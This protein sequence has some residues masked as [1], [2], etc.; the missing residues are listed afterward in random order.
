MCS[1]N[2]L[3]RN[4]G[5]ILRR[6]DQPQRVLVLGAGFT[7]LAAGVELTRLNRPF[8][9]VEREQAVG[10]LSKTY[11]MEGTSFELGPHIY[12]NKDPEVSRYWKFFLGDS[13]KPHSRSNRIYF[14]GA[15]IK[16]PLSPLD[17][18]SK[19]GLL[20]VTYMIWTFLLAKL[21]KRD[22][23]SAED[24]V[25]SNFGQGLYRYFFK[26]YNEKIWGLSCSEISPNWAG[27][28]IKSNLLTMVISSFRRRDKLGSKMFDFPDGGS[29]SLLNAQL[30][31]IKRSGI[32]EVKLACHPSEIRRLGEGFNVMFSDGTEAYFDY[33]IATCHLDELVALLR[34]FEFDSLKLL[35]RSKEL[36]YRNL[37]VVNLVFE[38][39]AVRDCGE[40]WIDVH[41]PEIKA[42]RVTNF[43]NY[44]KYKNAANLTGIQVEYN[45]F[46]TESV[47][48]ASDERL[49]QLAK[50][51][52]RRM[53]LVKG[54]HRAAG[55]VRIE[56]AYPVYFSGYEDTLKAILP[57]LQEIKGLQMAGRNAMY[58]WNNMHHSVKTGLLAARNCAGYDYDLATVEGMVV[59]G[60]ED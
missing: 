26:V 5:N 9:I 55:V 13:L 37:V 48:S 40:H 38:R 51:E 39:S 42:L 32:A 46:A 21:R 24:W 6:D 19:L 59:F 2:T 56:R 31:M 41:D 60:R 16:S 45:C 50:D 29:V 57:E 1:K 33:L 20:R 25:I 49:V 14:R 35:E 17:A 34:G 27:Q 22:I 58:R 4:S 12:F 7:G 43:G 47:W 30:E 23:K 54:D 52:L 8:T 18:L 10:G 36:M 3:K 15:F 44:Q 53:G 11:L 28:R